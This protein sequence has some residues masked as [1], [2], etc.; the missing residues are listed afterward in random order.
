VTLAPVHLFHY[1]WGQP[2]NHHVT[3]DAGCDSI[4]KPTSVSYLQTA[5]LEPVEC[6]PCRH[7]LEPD[8]NCNNPF[9]NGKYDGFQ[10]QAVKFKICNSRNNIFFAAAG[11]KVW[12]GDL[13]Q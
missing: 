7:L 12:L 13:K 9:S 2:T 6:E 5:G 1:N 3:A 4:E 11:L 8:E 10:E